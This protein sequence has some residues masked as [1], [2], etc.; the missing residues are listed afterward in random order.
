MWLLLPPHPSTK[1]TGK[2]QIFITSRNEEQHGDFVIIVSACTVAL[3]CDRF[4]LFIEGNSIQAARHQQVCA[5]QCLLFFGKKKIYF[6]IINWLSAHRVFADTNLHNNVKWF[7]MGALYGAWT[8]HS[9]H[10]HR[11]IKI[12]LHFI[13]KHILRIIKYKKRA[14]SL[15]RPLRHFISHWIYSSFITH[16]SQARI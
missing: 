14:R 2:T 3:N 10:T 8:Q 7:N 11:E 9:T 6:K 15:V 12:T 16:W 4:V 1:I 5:Y 13:Y